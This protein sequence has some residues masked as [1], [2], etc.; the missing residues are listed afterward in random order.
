MLKTRQRVYKQAVSHEE[1]V[2][3]IKAEAGRHFDPA[4]VAAFIQVHEK[5]KAI[6]RKYREPGTAVALGD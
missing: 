4:V 5:F 6:A 1:A 2:A 3:I